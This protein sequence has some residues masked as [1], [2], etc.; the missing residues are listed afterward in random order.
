MDGSCQPLA[1]GYLLSSLGGD[2]QLRLWR[3]A[4]YLLSSGFVDVR[5]GA[6]PG[7]PVGGCFGNL[8]LGRAYRGWMLDVCSGPAM[9]TRAGRDL[10]RRL[11]CGQSLSSGD[12]LLAQRVCRADGGGVAAAA[13][14]VGPAS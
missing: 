10:R 3:A 5:G 4:F 7:V 2:G 1:S 8:Y 9:A 12:R 13:A 11:L 14:D 6:G